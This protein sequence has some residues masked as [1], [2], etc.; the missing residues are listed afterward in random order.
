[1][2]IRA[3]NP[4]GT[5]TVSAGPG[6]ERTF[7][8]DGWRKRRNLIPRTTRWYGSLGLYDPAASFFASGR[9]L[10]DEGQLFFQSESEALRYLYQEGTYM[11]PVFNNRGLVFGFHVEDIPGG[12]PTRSVEVWQ[13]FINGQR[14]QSLRGANDAAV[15]VLQGSIPDTAQPH[16]AEVGYEVRLGDKE[17]SPE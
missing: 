16:P 12:E 7:A 15:T 9:L 5:V 3:T 14:P 4:K 17:Y 13:I 6:T 11:K 10:V 1:M 8:G 2:V